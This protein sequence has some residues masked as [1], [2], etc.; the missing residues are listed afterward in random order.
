MMGMMAALNTAVLEEETATDHDQPGD[1]ALPFDAHFIDGMIEHHQGAVAMAQL[2]LAEAEHEDLRTMAGRIIEAQQA[3]IEQMQTWRAE[4]HPDLPPT[5]GLGMH[6]GDMAVSADTAVPFDQR[7]LTAMISH[8]RGAITMA[9]AAQTQAEHDEL[10][11]MAGAIIAAQESEIAQMEAW[12][13][14]WYG[15]EPA[16]ADASGNGPASADGQADG[17]ENHH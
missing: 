16:S 4:W 10:R 8:H 15:I 17:H 5:T 12:L 1:P 6:M 7:F 14:E 9:E 2:A 11:Q 3:E 13:A